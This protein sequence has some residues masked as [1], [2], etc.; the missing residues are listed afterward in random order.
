[1]IAI[2]KVAARRPAVGTAPAFVFFRELPVIA[3]NPTQAGTAVVGRSEK[4]PQ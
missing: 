2:A 4:S 1:L 3:A